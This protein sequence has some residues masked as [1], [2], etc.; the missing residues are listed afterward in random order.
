VINMLKFKK[1]LNIF[2]GFE[3]VSKK[4]LKISIEKLGFLPYDLHVSE[5]LK[6]LEP[7]YINTS[8]ANRCFFDEIRDL[9]LKK[10]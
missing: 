1:E 5:S 7:Y 6:K 9:I 3:N 10:L 8:E 4:Y 2:Y